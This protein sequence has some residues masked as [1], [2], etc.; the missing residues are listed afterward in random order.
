MISPWPRSQIN[1]H[2]HHRRCA[3][4]SP[5]TSTLSEGQHTTHPDGLI[6]ITKPWVCFWFEC[7]FATWCYLYL[8][9]YVYVCINYL[10]NKTWYNNYFKP[11]PSHHHIDS[12]YMLVCSPFPVMD[13]LWHCYTHNIWANYHNSLPWIK[14]IWIWF[15]LVTMIPSEV[16]VR[17]S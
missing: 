4:V 5:W 11:Y 9:A 14:A 15:P 16:V 17:S 3:A 7:S 12:W 6:W 2:H 8:Y 1:H 10:I 13:G